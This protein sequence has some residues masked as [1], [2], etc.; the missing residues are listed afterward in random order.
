M[1]QKRKKLLARLMIIFIFG[2]FFLGF[3]A[4][5]ANAGSCEQSFFKCLSD[6]FIMNPAK[7]VYC[8]IGYI[9]CK[10]YIERA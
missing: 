2:A 4:P 1:Y 9:F 5:C 8:S 10:K 7:T 3:H 6:I